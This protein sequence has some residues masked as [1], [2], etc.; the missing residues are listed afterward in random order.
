MKTGI[1]CRV[2]TDEQVKEGYSIRAQ[3]EKLK[4]YVRIKDWE[5]YDIYI[6]EGISGKNIKE[7]PEVN[8]LIA[9]VMQKKIDNV[10]VFKID[11]LT[12]NTKDLITLMDLFKEN[13]CSFNSLMESID[14]GTASGRMFVKIIGIFAE[15]EREN[16]IERVSVA[17]E[18]KVREGYT[19]AS[20]SVPYGY[21][22]EKGNRNITINE[23]ESKVIQK[24]FSLYLNKHKSF[25]AIAT[26]LNMLNIPSNK[27]T[28]WSSS[29]IQYILRNP[30]YMGYV[31]YAIGDESRYFEAVGKHEPIISED[32]FLE[33]QSK[34]SKMKKIIKKR[35]REDNYYTG[36]LM[37][38][39]CG[40][41]MTTHG[42]YLTKKDGSEAY[43]CSYICSAKKTR[44]CTSS[45]MSHTKVEIAFREYIERVIDFRAEPELDAPENAVEEDTTLL[46]AEHENDHSFRAA[47]GTKRDETRNV[48]RRKI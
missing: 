44:N 42:Q 12:R 31:R 48:R 40:S 25:R 32:I 21:S 1:Y 19:I 18:K 38:G 2:S 6:D 15:F 33:V 23:E 30:I 9:D 39:I 29:S 28:E 20:F 10:L 36:T 27:S 45:S 34:L 8:R 46:K 41:K 3:Q 5:L 4:D 24:I 14:T 35:P 13:Q 47:K 17:F 22:R 16:L 43:Y 11:R 7:R 37:C 26:H